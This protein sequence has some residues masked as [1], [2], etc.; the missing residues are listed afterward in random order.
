MHEVRRTRSRL[1]LVVFS[2]GAST[3]FA[4]NRPACDDTPPTLTCDVVSIQL[5]PGSCVEFQNPC[6]DHQ[7][8]RI[9][10]FRLCDPPSG[11]YVQTQRNP[12]KRFLCADANV[13]ALSNEPVDYFYV[14]PGDT[15]LGTFRVTVGTAM[16]VSA[17]ANPA[18]ISLGGTSQLS[19]TISG[20]VPPFSF[21][22]SPTVGLDNPTAQNPIA[23]PT[24]NTQYTVT[25]TD[26]NGSQAQAS[27][28]IAVGMGV[29]VSATPG[30]IDPGQTS[31]LIALAQGG[32]PPYTYAWSPAASLDS[33]TIPFPNASPAHSTTYTVV[34]NDS[35]GGSAAGSVSVVV[36]LVVSANASPSTIDAGDQSQLDATVLGGTPPYTYLWSPGASLDDNTAQNPIASPSASTTYDVVVTDAAGTVRTASVDVTVVQAASLTACFTASRIAQFPPTV[37]MDGSCSVG[38]IVEYRWWFNYTWPGQPPDAVTTTPISPA[39]M[40]EL[41]GPVTLRLEVYDGANTAAAEQVF[42]ID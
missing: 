5:D 30:T 21:A 11:I 16:S 39:Y 34:V 19:T 33:A 3:L 4:G 2:I 26:D 12:R 13:A 1:A 20:G 9:D 14:R 22:W 41:F 8:R 42:T 32:V 18:V 38:A 35:A 27:V 40:Y 17:A 6:G 28:S 37:Q 10:G 31:S 15:G 36:N 25:V 29:Q 23:S 24:V 7:W